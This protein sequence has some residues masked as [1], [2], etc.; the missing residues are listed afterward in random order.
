M[1]K[2]ALV[3]ALVA[4]VQ[5]AIAQD[6]VPSSP[7][8]RAKAVQI[9]RALESDPLGKAAKEQR[10]WV[11]LWI[12]QVPD[13]SVTLCSHLLGPVLES[14]KNYSAE[15]FTQMV[16]SSAAFIIEHPEEAKDPA[17][18]YLA[19][20]EGALRTYEAIL[21]VK[22]KARWPYLDDLIEKRDKGTLADHV[23][24]ASAKCRS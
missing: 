8:D 9:A 23:R 13:I 16:P 24:D 11:T 3:L 14:K 21:K 22:P 7:E 18:V 2:S 6:R 20:V 15:I 12:I 19:G 17:R 10:R 4:V 1:R 5:L